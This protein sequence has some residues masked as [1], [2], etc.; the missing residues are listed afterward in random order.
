MLYALYHVGSLE[1]WYRD[2]ET[3]GGVAGVGEIN[4]GT[5]RTEAP[6]LEKIRRGWAT[7]KVEKRQRIERKRERER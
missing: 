1:P 2:A 4:V 3:V 6:S 7:M 5:R